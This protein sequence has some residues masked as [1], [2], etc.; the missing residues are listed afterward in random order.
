MGGERRAERGGGGRRLR[1]A[2]CSCVTCVGTASVVQAGDEQTGRLN[3]M[4][5][6]ERRRSS[7]VT[8]HVGIWVAHIDG[9]AS[10]GLAAGL[11]ARSA[12]ALRALCENVELHVKDRLLASSAND[13]GQGNEESQ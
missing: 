6:T 1:N 12:T 3:G 11:R 2:C 7:M 8:D 4:R 10:Q 5:T 9:G 13:Q